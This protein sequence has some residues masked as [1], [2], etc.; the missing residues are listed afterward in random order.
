MKSMA[1]FALTCGAFVLFVLRTPPC[2][3]GIIIHGTRVV[4]YAEQQEVI[5]RLE[6]KGS[7]PT[8]VQAWLDAGDRQS[9]PAKSQAPFTL[10]PPIFRI[11]PEQQQAL[12]LRYSGAPVP[13]DRE[14]LFWLNVLEIPPS[15]T[16]ATQ[17]NQIQ[18]SFRTRLRVF[19]RPQDLPYPIDNAVS[20]LQWK[21]VPHGTGH[22]LQ[23]TNPTPY[24]LS[25]A[26]V[27]LLSKGRRF[28][29][30]VNKD[31]NVAAG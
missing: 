18:L 25:L 28:K 4:Y 16:E 30:A 12:R 23:V 5:V 9:T 31:V 13:S 29:K 8:L 1:R 21:L 7:R 11:E 27:D 3:A 26:A 17:K 22:A 14:S 10:T 19:L 2:D 6:N 15:P 24:H 20:K